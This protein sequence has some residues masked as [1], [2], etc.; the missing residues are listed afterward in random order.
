M[1]AIGTGAIFRAKDNPAAVNATGAR[2]W[3]LGESELQG[4]FR[5]SCHFSCWHAV[6]GGGLSRIHWRNP[7]VNPQAHYIKCWVKPAVWYCKYHADAVRF[8]GIR[9]YHLLSQSR[10][11]TFAAGIGIG[12]SANLGTTTGAW[13]IAGFGLKVNIA[14]CAMPM[15]VFGVGMIFQSSK[16]VY[17]FGYIL[18]GPGFLFLGIHYMKE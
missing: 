12:F 5:R 4:Y 15:L 16:S 3:F 7:G 6:P 11:I 8:T 2:P 18:A 13:L 1:S 17:G 10:T 14:A 9:D